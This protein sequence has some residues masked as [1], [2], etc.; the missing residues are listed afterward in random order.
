MDLQHFIFRYLFVAPH[1]LLIP[2]AIVMFRK[3]L[4]RQFPVFFSYLCYE[5]LQFCVFYPILTR[6]LILPTWIYLD[7]DMF[8]KAGSTA[9]HFGI[10]QELFES[11]VKHDDSLRKSSTSILRWVTVALV[12]MASAFIG[13]QY[14]RQAHL[15]PRS[16]ASIEALNI[17][18]CFLLVLVFLWHRFLGHKMSTFAFGIALGL[19]LTAFLEPFF[20][21]WTDS[22]LMQ[23]AFIPDFLWMGTYHCSVLIWLYYALASDK[24]IPRSGEGPS[25]HGSGGGSLIEMRESAA[26]MERLVRR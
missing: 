25:R 16:Y 21:A 14:Y 5:F 11:P 4:H 19:G 6:L 17:A 22:R 15:L 23:R 20:S 13:F 7:L 8:F 1:V 12:V 26:E 9:F 2:V 18:Q 3:A 24:N 10:L